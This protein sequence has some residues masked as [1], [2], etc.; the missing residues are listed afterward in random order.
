MPHSRD[1]VD[2]LHAILLIYILLAK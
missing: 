1:N 2:V